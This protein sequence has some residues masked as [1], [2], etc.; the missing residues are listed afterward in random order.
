MTV[1]LIFLKVAKGF[2]AVQL[3]MCSQLMKL[4]MLVECQIMTSW[5]L[6]AYCCYPIFYQLNPRLPVCAQNPGD[7]TDTGPTRNGSKNSVT[8]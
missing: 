3:C 4:S 6:P 5:L 7:V 1:V 8:L 2:H